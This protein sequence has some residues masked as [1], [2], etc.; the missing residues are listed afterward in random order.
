MSRK[1]KQMTR[2]MEKFKR[3]T[4]QT[5][6]IVRKLNRSSVSVKLR[7]SDTLTRTLTK[8]RA[9]AQKLAGTT[10]TVAVKVKDQATTQLEKIDSMATSIGQKIVG[11]GAMAGI[12]GGALIGSG[13]SA[14]ATDAY[15]ATVTNMNVS[16]FT[17]MTDAIY[18]DKMIGTSRDDVAAAIV[19][20][21]Q[22]TKLEGDALREA[23]EAVAVFSQ[24][25]RKDTPE[26]ARAFA[27]AYKNELGSIKEIVDISSLVLT[28]SGDQYDDYLDTL[29]EYAS[30]FKGLQLNMGQVGSAFVAA[31]QAGARN[32]DEPADMFREFNIRRSEMT[33]DQILAFK[34]YFGKEKTAEIYKK[35]DAGT[36]SGGK[37]LSEFAIAL[38]KIPSF[39]R[40][41]AAKKLLGTKFEDI[42]EPMLAAAAA[43][44]EPITAVDE[45]MRNFEKFR[46]DNPLTPI[47]DSARTLGGVTKDIGQSI[48]TSVAPA[49]AEL[50]AWAKTTEG[51][52]A[53]KDFTASLSALAAV[54][55]NDLSQ[56][57]RW[58]IENWETVQPI[59]VTATTL[60]GG[61]VVVA[62]VSK[63]FKVLA[64]IIRWFGGA[65]KATLP[66]FKKLGGW[67]SKT[68]KSAGAVGPG[69]SKMLSK[70][71]RF[72]PVVGVAIGALVDFGLEMKQWWHDIQVVWFIAMS[73]LD[74]WG[75]EW[76][77]WFDDAGDSLN[78]F[79]GKVSSIWTSTTDLFKK[80]VNAIIDDVNTLI[81]LL[82]GIDITLP[83]AL[84]GGHIG[85]N[86]PTLN[87]LETSA[88]V[89]AKQKTVEWRNGSGLPSM[90]GGG[91]EFPRK[92]FGYSKNGLSGV[93][94]DDFPAMLHKRE[95][96]LPAEEADL[97]RSMAA[98]SGRSA[99]GGGAPN[100]H[101]EIS[102]DNHYSND[103]DAERVGNIAW[104][105]VNKKMREQYKTGVQGV[106]DI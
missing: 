91:F 13:S 52:A 18:Y 15:G 54:F 37:V 76:A 65:G 72:V 90:P 100:V 94:Y 77:A 29:N 80:G 64:S 89:E 84:G 85:F 50:A 57:I 27:S 62:K 21:A 26:V 47:T 12:S 36:L 8:V 33:D 56:G 32:Y 31:V 7:A 46:N 96:V 24:V 103:M 104:Q 53:I 4:D 22:Q 2:P 42:G 105:T 74:M 67:L 41:D 99:R 79:K 81:R 51:Q 75:D 102:G 11:F 16:D 82:N 14:F 44:A 60:I 61:L 30:S 63:L 43:L 34:K 68:G 35:M 38:S 70:F 83:E 39:A 66:W 49:F 9:Q 20:F 25:H 17:G 78:N 73:A 86:I 3:T 98:S 5:N 6:K 93:P 48:L 19:D 88:D 28:S 87:P 10:V 59:L 71:G 45:M 69:L 55:A 106:Y 95:T 1:L 101:V 92:E 58:T 23:A 40:N 97:I